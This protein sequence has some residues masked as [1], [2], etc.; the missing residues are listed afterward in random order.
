VL[1]LDR[2]AGSYLLQIRLK[3]DKHSGLD[4]W[5]QCSRTTPER[6]F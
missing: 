6:K 3:G 2:Q 1:R 5:G 4:R